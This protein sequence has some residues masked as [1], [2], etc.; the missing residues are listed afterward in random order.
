MGRV[1]EEGPV[2][3]Q[4]S[5]LCLGKEMK[6]VCGGTYNFCKRKHENKPFKF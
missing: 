1:L 4:L 5:V 3:T 6:V 2:F